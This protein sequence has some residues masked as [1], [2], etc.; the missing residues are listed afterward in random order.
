MTEAYYNPRVTTEVTYRE[1]KAKANKEDEMSTTKE[2][3]KRAKEKNK[4]HY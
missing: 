1:I 4:P 2:G 3:R